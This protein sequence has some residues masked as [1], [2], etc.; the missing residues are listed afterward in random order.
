MSLLHAEYLKLSRRKIYPVMVIILLGL[1]AFLG[2]FF[3]FFG[4]LFPD[5]G[6]PAIPKPEAFVFGAQQVA[7]QTWFP[8]ILGVVLLGGELGSTF[9][10]T[11][12]TREPS[13][14]RHVVSRLAALSLASWLA[15][16]IGAGVWAAMAHF[17]ATGSGGLDAGEWLGVAWRMGLVALVWSSLG[18]AAV[19][20]FRSVGPAIGAVLAFYFLD[21][22]L[23]FWDRW[24]D[25]SLYVATNALFGHFIDGPLGALIPG[26]GVS[27]ARALAV[28]LGW[29]AVALALTWWG[30]RRRDA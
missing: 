28:L 15:Y 20:M 2:F 30:L 25:V 13:V 26:A 11:S 27:A 3:L 17:G 23:A 18:L 4:D 29:T 22:I 9:W 1:V 7:G 5:E 10:A 16:L 14:L 12:L 19:A 6:I 24:A 21:Q 8:L